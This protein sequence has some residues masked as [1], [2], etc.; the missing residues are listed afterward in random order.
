[1]C[2][3][4]SLIKEQQE[5]WLFIKERQEQWLFLKEQQEQW[6]L[7][8]ERQEQWLFLKERQERKST[9][10][11]LPH[12]HQP[13]VEKQFKNVSLILHETSFLYLKIRGSHL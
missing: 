9:F 8:K 12:P 4:P 7:I 2:S 11:T 6:L 1:M 13:K 3:H 10:P 5:Q